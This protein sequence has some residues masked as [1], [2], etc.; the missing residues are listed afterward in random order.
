MGLDRTICIHRVVIDPT[1]PNTVYAAAIGNPYAEH[2]ERGVFKTTD[3]GETWNKILY[4][5][6][7]TGCADLVMDPSNPNKLIAAMWQFRRTPWNLKMPGCLMGNLEELVLL[8]VAVCQEGCMQK[9]RQQ[10]TVC[11][12]VMMGVLNGYW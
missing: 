8:S 9:L 12:K 2:P 11:T 6:D 3:G 5:N 7:T 1:N 4:A 10:K